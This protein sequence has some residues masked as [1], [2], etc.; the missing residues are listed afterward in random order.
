MHCPYCNSSVIVPEELRRIEPAKTVFQAGEMPGFN[1][2]IQ[3][4][5]QFKDV[6]VLARS[7]KEIEAIK[8][9]RQLTG[10]DLA[11]AKAAVELIRSGQPVMLAQGAQQTNTAVSPEAGVEVR[12]VM[13][14]DLKVEMPAPPS[15][16]IGNWE[17]IPTPAPEPAAKKEGWSIGG[18]VG[19]IVPLL[20]HDPN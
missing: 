10:A 18:C 13:P 3:E 4:A 1:Q 5:S 14:A 9:Y 2:L 8:L 6:A 11:A 15:G 20:M 17:D 7:G 12:Q 19:W 16:E